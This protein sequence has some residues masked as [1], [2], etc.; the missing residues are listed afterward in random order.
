MLT[1]HHAIPSSADYQYP[2]A[3]RRVPPVPLD[4]HNEIDDFIAFPREVKMLPS[5]NIHASFTLYNS[6]WAN[7][8]NNFLNLTTS[9]GHVVSG[10]RPVHILARD[11]AVDLSRWLPTGIELEDVHTAEESRNILG[12]M[13]SDDSVDRES[14]FEYD[15]YDRL[16]LPVRACANEFNE[17][18]HDLSNRGNSVGLIL[19]HRAAYADKTSSVHISQR[20][21]MIRPKRFMPIIHVRTGKATV[22]YDPINQGFQVVSPARTLLHETSHA[23]SMTS[24]PFTDLLSTMLWDPEHESMAELNANQLT[25]QP[26][27]ASLIGTADV[28]GGPHEEPLVAVPQYDSPFPLTHGSYADQ[29]AATRILFSN[30]IVR[31]PRQSRGLHIVNRSKR[32]TN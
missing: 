14:F 4:D 3:V 32:L 25:G 28:R 10:H 20:N 2:P 29:S 7:D 19:T 11:T 30:V 17:F 15:R 5:N 6:E 23:Q 13:L 12:T 22:F 31:Y 16:P 27:H 24:N 18:M 21:P 26:S 9:T 8:P 1:T